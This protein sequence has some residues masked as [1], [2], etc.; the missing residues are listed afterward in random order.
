LTAAWRERWSVPPSNLPNFTSG[1]SRSRC[2]SS[3]SRREEEEED[4]GGGGL[5]DDDDDDVFPPPSTSS[6]RPAWEK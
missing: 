2:G 1:E 4:A 6:A 5:D 3:A